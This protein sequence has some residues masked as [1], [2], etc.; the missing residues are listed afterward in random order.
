MIGAQQD[1]EPAAGYE[2]DEDELVEG[3]DRNR[4]SGV[5][6]WKRSSSLGIA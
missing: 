6:D 3:R 2:S 4:C 1:A 5:M